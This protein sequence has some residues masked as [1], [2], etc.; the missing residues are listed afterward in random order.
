MSSGE[1]RILAND[2][3]F[4]ELVKYDLRALIELIIFNFSSMSSKENIVTQADN[5]I[6]CNTISQKLKE[7]QIVAES[8]DSV[9]RNTEE[10][11]EIF[12]HVLETSSSASERK[13]SSN[14][15]SDVSSDFY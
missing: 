12:E 3:I 5:A 11:F 7:V 9:L 6:A 1:K 10:G 14:N 15:N 2:Q 8:L 4:I 13:H